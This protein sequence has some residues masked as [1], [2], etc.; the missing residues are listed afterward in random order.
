[1]EHGILHDNN[2]VKLLI[3]YA[4]KTAKQPVS[5]PD[6]TDMI[7]AGGSA[8]YFDFSEALSQLMTIGHIKKVED[9]G[10]ELLAAT[11]LG[12]DTVEL[13]E[14]RLPYSVRE[15]TMRIVIQTL[16]KIRADADLVCKVEERSSGFTVTCG[17]QDLDDMLFQ[18]SLAVANRM[19]ADLIVRRF[20]ENPEYIYRTILLLLTDDHSLGE[21]DDPQQSL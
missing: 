15:K 20:K 10:Q 9:E 1:M 7:M 21:P 8:N 14:K 19:Q 4:L 16:S 3:L 18:V 2:D 12:L 17:V 6:L 11:Q 13:F 5:Q